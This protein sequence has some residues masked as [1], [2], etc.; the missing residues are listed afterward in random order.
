MPAPPE[1]LDRFAGEQDGADGQDTPDLGLKI[2][3]AQVEVKAVLISLDT[4]L[5]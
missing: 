3:R 2:W 1:L 5:I 4:A